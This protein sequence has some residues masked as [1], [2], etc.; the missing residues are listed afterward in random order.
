M[1]DLRATYTV[2]EVWDSGRVND[3]CG[4]RLF[5]AAVRDETGLRGPR[6]YARLRSRIWSSG[7]QWHSCRIERIRADPNRQRIV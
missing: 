5:L 3:I 4:Y 7:T 1:P 6:R 2:R